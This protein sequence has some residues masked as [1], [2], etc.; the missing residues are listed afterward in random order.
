[1][2]FIT[3]SGIFGQNAGETGYLK[4][5]LSATRYREYG[6]G[7]NRV[8]RFWPRESCTQEPINV[9]CSNALEIPRKRVLCGLTQII[10]GAS[11]G[12]V[13]PEGNL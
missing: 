1:M 9:F 13:L 12:L 11:C 5:P 4:E 2:A 6:I 8:F 7:G 10:S 3:R